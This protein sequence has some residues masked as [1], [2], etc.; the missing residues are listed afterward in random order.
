MHTF[1][2]LKLTFARIL[3]S[4]ELIQFFCMD[5]LEV[6]VLAL[7]EHKFTLR[8]VDL[9]LRLEL[10]LGELRLE[11]RPFFL[12]L[13]LFLIDACFVLLTQQLLLFLKLFFVFLP[14]LCHVLPLFRVSNLQLGKLLLSLYM[15]FINGLLEVTDLGLVLLA[16]LNH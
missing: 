4:P 13:L 9:S 2:R 10:K 8:L 15:G 1:Y 12:I 5:N 6:F 16:H 14:L 11:E 3:Q 7:E